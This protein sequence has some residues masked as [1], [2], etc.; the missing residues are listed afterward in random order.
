MKG[1]VAH[2]N[3]IPWLPGTLEASLLLELPEPLSSASDDPIVSRLKECHV[4][5]SNVIRDV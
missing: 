5:L 4:L 1:M 3:V 2:A